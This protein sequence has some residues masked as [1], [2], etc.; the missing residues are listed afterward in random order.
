M[1]KRFSVELS[2]LTVA[3]I[4]LSTVSA[5]SVCVLLFVQMYSKAL[6]RDARVNSER[7][8]SLAALS[9]DNYLDSIK[10]NLDHIR[11]L[12]PECESTE[13][14]GAKMAAFCKLQTDIY[15]VTVYDEA[16]SPFLCVS[17]GLEVKQNRYAGLLF[18]KSG[19]TDD[20]YTVSS[21]H[22]QS[23]FK[24]H[25]PWV[26]T[27]STETDSP[28]FGEKVRVAIDFR[29]YEIAKYID[30]IGMGRH[31][32][33][34]VTDKNGNIVYHP[35]QQLLYAGLKTE[36]KDIVSL[37]DGV[38]TLGNTT[39]T[40][41]TAS[42]GAWR[43]VGVSFTD[44]LA[45]ERRSQI[46]TAVSGA[47]LC[48]L[49]VSVAALVLFSRLVNRPVKNLVNAMRE[50]EKGAKDFE[51]RAGSLSVAELQ[52]LSDSFAHMSERIKLLVERVRK[53]QT[54]LRK[55]ELKALQAQIN[56]HF[57]YNTLDSIQWMCESGNTENAVK[58]VGALAK[59][60]RIS[61]S[62]GKEFITVK[63]E[64][65][66]AKS[67][68]VI[69]SF[70][71][72]DQFSY[73]FDIEPGLE[74]YL[75]N[76]ITVQPLVENAIY[77]GIDRMVDEGE[78]KI[79]V[80]TAPD[81]KSDILITVSDNGVG[82]TAEQCRK[83]LQKEKSDSSGIGV[84]NVNDR[85]VIYFGKKYGLTIESEPDVGTTVTVRIPKITKELENEI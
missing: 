64:M 1:K 54:A 9:V 50:F 80:K 59:L 30:H 44:E 21:P 65:E 42:S 2:K 69:Q 85:L 35:Q 31:G 36:N 71:Y 26:V 29:F 17:D 6:L 53:D 7:T 49:I 78:I 70:R 25:Y 46:L 10:N 60:F 40:L 18:D 74:S 84:K 67:Y 62:R 38:H 81:C 47:F 83:I 75:C 37:A 48:C 8:V 66:H 34:Y 20:G 19:I 45:A 27:I 76:K 56:P 22:V 55:T 12:M 68:L 63:E 58:M 72:K 28:L 39:Y 14:F 23:L 51:Y 61:I 4:V 16:G 82:M 33:C 79:C 3:L 24:G 73:H 5:V 13:D 52:E 15:A 57:L 32:Y 41:D 77:H 11:E 43:V